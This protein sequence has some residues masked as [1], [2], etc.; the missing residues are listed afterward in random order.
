[1]GNVN[2]KQI[3]VSIADEQTRKRRTD[4]AVPA[5]C[6]LRETRSGH[7]YDDALTIARDDSERVAEPAYGCAQRVR[8]AVAE[9]TGLEP[10]IVAILERSVDG[11]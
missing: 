8:H 3:Q 2:R 10:E 1:M 11:T 5:L 4:A 7:I 6:Q 9:I